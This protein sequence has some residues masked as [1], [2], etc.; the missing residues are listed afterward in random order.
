MAVCQRRAP[1]SA[2]AGPELSVQSA[3]VVQ[4]RR[5]FNRIAPICGADVVGMDR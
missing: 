1:D 2:A 3:V 4:C 5:E